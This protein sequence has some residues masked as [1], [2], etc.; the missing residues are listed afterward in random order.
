M[1]EVTSPISDADVRAG[2]GCK[3]VVTIGPACHDVPTLARMLRAG[4]TCAR[5][6]L[7]WGT[8]VS[9]GGQGARLGCWN[10]RGFDV[11]AG[12]ESGGVPG[13]PASTA[14]ASSQGISGGE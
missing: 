13:R 8:K 14:P 9:A 2:A 6:N 1:E 5:V 7:S 3:V 4:V 10:A 12:R 11:G